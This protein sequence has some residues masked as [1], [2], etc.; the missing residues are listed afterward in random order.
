V[1][2]ILG[3]RVLFV[4]TLLTPSLATYPEST[5]KIADV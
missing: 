2:D 1:L 4:K 3:A 5:A